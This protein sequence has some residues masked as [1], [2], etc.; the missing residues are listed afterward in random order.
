[1]KIQGARCV[2]TGASSGIGREVSLRL[3]EQGAKVMGVARSFPDESKLH[4]PLFHEYACDVSEPEKV[5]QLF[6]HA[7]GVMG[8]IDLFFANAGFAY[9]EPL[10]PPDWGHIEAIYRVNVFSVIYSLEKMRAL[11]NEDGF[12]FLATASGIS[13]VPIPN[14][15]LYGSTKAALHTFFESM[16]Y[17][18]PKHQVLSVVYPIA[19]KTRFFQ[20]ANRPSMP[21]PRQDVKVVA[22]AII[23]GI[24]KDRRSIHP[25]WLFRIGQVVFALFPWGKKIYAYANRA[26]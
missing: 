15:A 18:T 7:L 3:L 22:D 8:G 11:K 25:S 24:Q 13:F 2:I 10:G 21:W 12:F 14:F 1:M 16:A 19:T 26:F 9:H 17:E 5:D 4:H 6:A 20:K 23:R